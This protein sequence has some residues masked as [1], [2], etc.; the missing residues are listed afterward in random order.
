MWDIYSGEINGAIEAWIL[1]VYNCKVHYIWDWERYKKKKKLS[2]LEKIFS[3]DNEEDFGEKK[4][5]LITLF[6]LEFAF[7]N[8]KWKR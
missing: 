3:V 2:I 4:Y 1:D 8:K 5:K 6:G 7:V